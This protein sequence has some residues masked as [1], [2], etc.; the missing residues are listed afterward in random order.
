MAN[1]RAQIDLQIHIHAAT[2]TRTGIDGA[3]NALRQEIFVG[4]G[5]DAGLRQR[6]IDI[7]RRRKRGSEMVGALTGASALPGVAVDVGTVVVQAAASGANMAIA[8]NGSERARRAHDLPR[9]IC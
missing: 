4:C 5:S 7:R 3:D 9:D 2:C 1:C 6:R 8:R